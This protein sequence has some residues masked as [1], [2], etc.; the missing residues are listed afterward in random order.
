MRILIVG[1]GGREHALAWKL[2]QSPLVD[3]LYIAPG[4][5]GTA[6]LGENIPIHDDDLPGLTT[7]A[8]DNA[9][10][11]VVI[12]PE[13]PLVLGLKEA[14]AHSGI[15]CFGPNA[16][17]AQLEGSKAFAKTVMRESG[18]PTAPFRVFDDAKDA[19]LHIAERSMP[20]VVKADGLA[21]GKGVVVCSS[22]EE[23][24]E[25]IDEMMVKQV[26]G[27]AGERVVIEDALRGEEASFLAFC[28]GKTIVCMPSSQDHKAVGE[29]D[30]G[31]N[32]GGM[33][34]YSPA[35]IL[36]PEDYEMM[37]D[38]VIR[39]IVRHMAAKDNPFVGV[40]YAGIMF[41]ENGPQVLEY[42]VRFGDPECQPLL[43][44]LDSDLAE[45]MTACI[46][47]RLHEID[48]RWKAETAICVVMAADGYPRSYPKGMEISG[49]A[50]AETVEGVTVFQAGTRPEDGRILASGG[51]VLGV[52][53]LGADLAQAQKRAYEGI[54][55]IHFDKSYFRRDIG[56][57]GLR[58]MK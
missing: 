35:P 57:K 54:E 52:T 41:T 53:A 7:F 31:P 17:A 6:A 44:R 26:F 51:R 20:C 5:G 3:K 48:I 9:I 8:K 33:G 12:G 24:L 43:T 34:A 55:K 25:A 14:L 38:L 46:E 56:D 13:L 19:R 42:N 18:V 4:N 30:T 37:T 21:A 39:P 22:R 16:F 49:F 27:K 45:I 36:P 1:S 50:E 10:D 23:A 58:R 40:L 15:P 11:M 2:S 32:T 28:D 47:G 29:G